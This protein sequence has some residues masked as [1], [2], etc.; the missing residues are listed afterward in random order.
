M[1]WMLGKDGKMIFV[2]PGTP[3]YGEIPAPLAMNIVNPQDGQALVYDG[4][5]GE[6]VNG[7]GGGGGGGSFDPTITNPQDGQVLVYDG[8]AGK[9]VNG[10]ASGGGAYIITTHYDSETYAVVFE[11][12]WQEI[13]NAMTANKI[14]IAK[15]INE[16]ESGYPDE[17][18]YTYIT[19]ATVGAEDHKYYL[20][21]SA[22]QAYVADTANDY[23]VQKIND[24]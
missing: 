15:V 6:W 14:C 22:E 10:A 16:D 2:E 20:F 7:E 23:P 19:L 24:E 1:A 13:Y 3:V 11:K 4:E 17:I 12:T 8:T 5:K 18:G 21:D 9:W